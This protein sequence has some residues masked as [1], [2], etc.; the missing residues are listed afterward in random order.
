M[1][2]DFLQSHNS[3]WVR[4]KGPES[5][6]VLSTRIR[7]ARN[8]HNLPFPNCKNN[9]GDEVIA[10]TINLLNKKTATNSGEFSFIKMSSLDS[11][12]KKMLVEKHL[13]SPNLAEATN[14][15]ACL[16]SENEEISIMINEED[17][18]R[19]QALSAGFQ[20]VETL[21][22]ALNI[23]NWLEEEVT[24]SYDEKL[25]Y[26]TTCPSNVGTG[27]R[28]SVMMH[29][30]L[31]VVTEKI[32]QLIQSVSKMGLVVRGVY[33]EGSKSV[34]NIFQISNQITTGKSETTIIEELRN[35]VEQ[36][37][38]HERHAR[39]VVMQNSRLQIEDRIY[40]SLGILEQ[41]RLLS[42]SEAALRLSDLR[43]GIDTQIITNIPAEI[44]NEL[45]VATQPAFLQK[46]AARQLS[47]TERDEARATLIRTYIKQGN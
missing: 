26:L 45:I 8:I 20:L 15:G 5:D 16:I 2:N 41:A 12:E 17:H 25:G 9:C 22:N 31:L 36:I 39:Q 23:D 44:F 18:F 27:L 6:I 24:Y 43:T 32:E 10:Q 13:I 29:L 3:P 14:E 11:L 30:P 21:S 35:V 34:G 42:S 28:A 37:I 47:A 46:M 1:K 40:R 4:K 7:L 19:I 38:I 33:G